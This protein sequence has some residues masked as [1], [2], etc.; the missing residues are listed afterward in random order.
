M[1]YIPLILLIIAALIFFFK[2]TLTEE[3]HD[4]IVKELN[5]RLEKDESTDPD[6]AVSDDNNFV[7][8]TTVK[9]GL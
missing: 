7:A 8:P 4:E 6:S 2:V 1:F 3:K 9:T 5:K